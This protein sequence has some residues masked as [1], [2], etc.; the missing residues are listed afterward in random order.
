MPA[1]FRRLTPCEFELE[2]AHFPW[3][4]RIWRVD[5]HHTRIP[6]HADYEGAMTVERMAW[7]DTVERGFDDIAQ[8][9]SIAPDGAIWTGRDWNKDPVSVGFSMN[10]G[11]FMLEAI[12]NFDR[13]FDRLEG[14]QLDS[15]VR[16]TNAVQ[17]QFR[18]PVQALLF[19]REVPQ[20]TCPG[21]CIDKKLIMRLMAGM[22]RFPQPVEHGANAMVA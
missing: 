2:V 8:H 5:M 12:G 6:A 10:A 13:G 14:R 3:C 18:L 7:L 17:R 19:H 20:T 22:R 11:V 15:V 4:R 21:M 1:P 9:V 16:V